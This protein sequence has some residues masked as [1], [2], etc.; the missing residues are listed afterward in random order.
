[1]PPANNNSWK[2]EIEHHLYPQPD[3]RFKILQSSIL[4]KYRDTTIFDCQFSIFEEAEVT[5]DI[6]T[7]I[8]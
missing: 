3:L 6:L 7:L 5:P 4:N 8:A 2:G 1:M